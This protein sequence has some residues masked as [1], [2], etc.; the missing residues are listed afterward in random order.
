MF[1]FFSQQTETNRNERVTFVGEY[2]DGLLK[3][4]AA[5]CSKKDQFARKKGVKIAEGRLSKNRLIFK[6]EMPDCS[7]KQFVDISKTLVGNIL[8]TKVVLM[9]VTNPITP[10]E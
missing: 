3:I 2:S 4:A 8:Q 1:H 5:R 7:P 6:Q 9:A 10:V